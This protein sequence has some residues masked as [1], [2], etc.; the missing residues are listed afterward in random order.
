MKKLFLTALAFF[1]SNFGF[2]QT[3]CTGGFAGIFPCN[4][5]DLMSNMTFTQI[6]GTAST[7]GNECWGWTDPL[8]GKEY[9]LMGCTTHLAFIDISNAA[10]P[11]YVGKVNSHN[12]VTSLWRSFRVYNNYVFIVSEAAGHGMQVF[13]LTRLRGVTTP[14]TFTPDARYAGF[15]NCHTIAINEASGYAYCVGTSTYGGGPHVVNIQ[16]PLIPVFS[17]GYSAQNYCHEAQ[18][19]IYDGP[20]TEH[21][22]KEIFIG[23]NTNKVVIMDV[24]NKSNP[25]VLSTFTYANTSYTHQGWFTPDQKY[26]LLGDELD[27]TNFGFNSRTLIIDFTNLDS[28]ILKGEYYGTT[29]AIDHNGYTKGNDFY[30]ANYRAGLRILNTANITATS[31]M[32]EIG[33]FD[34][35]PTSN[36]AAFNGAWNVYPYFASGNILISDIE[37]GLFVVK[38]NAFLGVDEFDTSSFTMQPNPSNDAVTINTSEEIKSID[39]YDVVGKQVKSYNSISNSTFTFRVEDLKQGLYIVKINNSITKKLIVK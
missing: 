21:V 20:D 13:D 3:I 11:V 29:P 14:Q 7:E 12:N 36:S 22:G 30:L 5:I 25:I 1:L 28:P 9:A 35:F 38:K 19:V 8:T 23:A 16:N 15:G 34:T 6:G 33:F 37:R 24:S 32:N 17:F 39:V 10:A 4:N 2:A 27:E 31:T 26:W 18:V